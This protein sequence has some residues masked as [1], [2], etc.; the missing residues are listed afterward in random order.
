[1]IYSV[2]VIFIKKQNSYTCGY[3][4][5]AHLFFPNLTCMSDKLINGN[6]F[7]KLL[8][9]SIFLYPIFNSTFQI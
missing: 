1:M 4:P 6:F 9:T 2:Y 5:H 7:P 3:N 8:I